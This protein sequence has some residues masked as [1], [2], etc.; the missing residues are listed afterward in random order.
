M[1]AIFVD[2]LDFVATEEGKRY[3]L[4]WTFGDFY[5]FFEFYLE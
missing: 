5:K 2:P 3:I 1:L 4:C